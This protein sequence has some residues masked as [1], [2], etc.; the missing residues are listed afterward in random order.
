M[1][2]D[3]SKEPKYFSIRENIASQLRGLHFAGKISGKHL[4]IALI[5]LD[6]TADKD[7]REP[8]NDYINDI[9]YNT[10]LLMP[11]IMA[12]FSKEE[13]IQISPLE[14]GR[15]L[16]EAGFRLQFKRK[17]IFTKTKEF[18]INM[19]GRYVINKK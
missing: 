19:L 10:T 4:C 18:I 13:Q 9:I 12:K 5:L 3:I 7:L 14:I 11:A 16:S 17:S 6:I 1:Q 2:I 15:F 8:T